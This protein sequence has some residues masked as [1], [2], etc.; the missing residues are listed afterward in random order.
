MNV[1]V[2]QDSSCAPQ[3]KFICKSLSRGVLF[4]LYNVGNE[5]KALDGCMPHSGR[6]GVSCV[7]P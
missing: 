3:I 2:P 1:A 7:K 5:R 6:S 4:W